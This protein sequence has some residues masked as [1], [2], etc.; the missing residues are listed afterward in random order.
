[1]Q[2]TG[3]DAAASLLSP[4]QA[5]WPRYELVGRLGT[6]AL[7]RHTVGADLAEFRSRGGVEIRIERVPGRAVFTSRPAPGPQELVHPLA[8]HLAAIT[9]WWSGREC[10]HAGAYI[11]EG[12]VWALMGDR[13]SGKSSTLAV[14][15][16]EGHSIVC[17]DMLVLDGLQPFPG[18]R[19]IDLRR[20]TA[21]RLGAGEPLGVVGDR[22]R[23]RLMLDSIGDVPPLRGIVYLAWGEHLTVRK[24][25]V[26]RRLEL[27]EEH[28]GVSLPLRSPAVWLSLA[29]L[30]AWE[31]S[32]PRE[33][34]SL[35]G[36][37]AQLRRLA[38]SSAIES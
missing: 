17:D 1:L 28:R 35:P 8:A 22:E 27:L 23:W 37:T 33:W 15:A 9:A 7:E 29:A 31:V 10:F 18:P 19:S 26:A 6:P 34:E 2:L 32:R 25:D 20:E 30:P 12:G 16:T 21:D 4:A 3:V 38:R 24:V 13:G 11:A 5:D 14:L 36:V